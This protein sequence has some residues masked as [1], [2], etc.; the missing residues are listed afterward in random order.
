MKTSWLVGIVALVLD[1]VGSGLYFNQSQTELEKLRAAQ[2]KLKVRVESATDKYNREKQTLA[3]LS[4]ELRRSFP[5]GSSAQEQMKKATQLVSE[6]DFM[7]ENATSS[8]PTLWIKNSST[9]DTFINAKRKEI[10]LLI[11]E[12]QKKQNTLVINQINVAE[13][14]KIKDGVETIQDFIADLFDILDN[15]TPENSTFSQSQIDNYLSQLPALTVITQV[16]NT[17]E[18]SIQQEVATNPTSPSTNSNSSE[19]TPAQVS[20][21]ET[22]VAESEA[23]L[24][25]LEDQLAIIEEQIEALINPPVEETPIEELAEEEVSS[26]P[27]NPQ[28]VSD[29]SRVDNYQVQ[30]GIIV[31]PGNPELIDGANLY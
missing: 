13:S 7:F 3:A 25:T 23:D 18:N 22:V 1:S 12:W 11:Q 29:T 24:Q 26:S 15:L 19:P 5:L 20:A 28:D 16:L 4:D 14:Q 6:T 30:Q 31:Q 9:N 27:T 2:D 21:Q 10:N 8:N 17:L